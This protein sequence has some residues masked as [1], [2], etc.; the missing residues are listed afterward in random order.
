M[1]PVQG[2]D[3]DREMLNRRIEM[4]E[5]ELNAIKSATTYKFMKSLD[6]VYIP[7]RKQLKGMI[8]KR[9]GGN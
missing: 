8:E 5:A 7:F 6:H 3:F 4:A 2:A 9:N 1:T